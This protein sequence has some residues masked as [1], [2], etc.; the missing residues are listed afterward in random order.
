MTRMRLASIAV[1]ALFAA[2]LVCVR[3]AVCCAQSGDCFPTG[4]GF[5]HPLQTDID[6][7][8]VPSG[9]N[10]GC[11]QHTHVFFINGLDPLNLGNFYCLSQFVRT[12]GYPNTY[13]GQMPSNFRV[14]DKIK[15]IRRCDA[16]ARIVLVGYSGGTYVVRTLAHD[17][18]ADGIDVD[19]L[20]YLGGDMI[21]NTT[22]RR[23]CNARRILNITGNGLLL[24]GGNLLWKGTTL[25]CAVNVRIP[26]RHILLPSRRETIQLLMN[27][28]GALSTTP[29]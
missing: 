9:P 19:L 25:D 5:T 4:L 26:V 24:T 11:H 20:V 16:D 22:H 10:G 27:E 3:P 12:H 2:W 13:F 14:R 6:W 29:Q 7:N 21:H 18:Q 1:N 8:Q 23:P 28:F 15:E 17:L